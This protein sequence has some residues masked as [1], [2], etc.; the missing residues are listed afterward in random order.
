MVARRWYSAHGVRIVDRKR[1]DGNPVGMRKSS[2]HGA[3]NDGT[4]TGRRA[5]GVW[6]REGAM[7]ACLGRVPRSVDGGT[8]DEVSTEERD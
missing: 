6:T 4:P 1:D 5:Q 3:R 7:V 8:D 2:I